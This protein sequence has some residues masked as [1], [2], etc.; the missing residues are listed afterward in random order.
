MCGFSQILTMFTFLCRNCVLREGNVVVPY[1]AVATR[2][3]SNT[4]T[5][6]ENDKN[7]NK[8]IKSF[9]TPSENEESTDTSVSMSSTSDTSSTSYYPSPESPDSVVPGS[10]SSSDESSDATIIYDASQ[11]NNVI[12]VPEQHEQVSQQ[13]S[14][15]DNQTLPGS[16]QDVN[17]DLK[18]S[19]IHTFKEFARC[20]TF[21]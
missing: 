21:T 16:L 1:K 9:V 15:D 11:Y 4:S 20:Y 6:L 19:R 18:V 3:R 8:F 5:K 17:L 12:N 10:T 14:S 2:T 13:G 7:F